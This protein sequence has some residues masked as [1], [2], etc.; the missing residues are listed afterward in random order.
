MVSEDSIPLKET[1]S[2]S[3]M[4]DEPKNQ[5]EPGQQDRV[6][7]MIIESILSKPWYSTTH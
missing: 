7:K 5:I 4:K 3:E 1:E 6:R 2:V